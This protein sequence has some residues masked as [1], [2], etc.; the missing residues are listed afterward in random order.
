[1]L[2][3]HF[4]RLFLVILIKLMVLL[5]IAAQQYHAIHGSSYAGVSSA[6][7]N[8]ASIGNSLHRW[9]IQLFSGQTAIYTNT[10]Y[11]QSLK[12]AV[13]GRRGTY[14]TN[15]FQARELNNN[16]DM[17]LFSAMYRINK[18]HAVSF[19]FRGKMYNHVYANEFNHQDSSSSI[20][21]FF[22]SNRTT[23]FLESKSVNAGWG[24]FNLTYAGAIA[25]TNNSRLT[26]GGSLQISKS[27]FGGYTNMSK[28]RF[29]ESIN[30][31]DTN[32]I[33]YS[34]VAEYGYSSNIDVIQDDG[35]SLSTVKSF[36]KQARTSVGLSIGLEYL[37]YDDE[38]DLDKR[39]DGGRLY[40][41]KIGFSIVDIGSQ[42]FNNSPYTGRFIATNRTISPS[43]IARAFRGL[44]NAQELRDS[45]TMLFD[46]AQVLPAQFNIGN[47]TRAI[48]NFDK[49][50]KPNFF[51]NA[52]MVV[53]LS[54]TKNSANKR[55]NDYSFITIT[56]RWENLNWGI[57]LPVQYTRDGQAWVGFAV[58]AGPFI[59]GIHNI[60]I[61]KQRS[62]LNG[63]GYILLNIHPFRKKE[64]KSRIDCFE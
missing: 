10:I 28:L 15:G 31:R 25:E 49:Q 16:L 29:R 53:H 5:P 38:N 11:A 22:K 57:Y 36:M 51:V 47:P 52:Q 42:K 45:L 40:N 19:A 30:G 54:N 13:L 62:L 43:N 23:P 41:Y 44:D 34:G 39:N 27:F 56:P 26:I 20:Y 1:M 18:K 17:S 50:I 48:F 6:F 59:G 61:I 8:P 55:T 2:I 46:S 12:N 21:G 60:G 35:V 58:K 9:D 14:L 37:Q 3:S 4:T 24:E 64:M 32:Y 7:N 63:G 33:A